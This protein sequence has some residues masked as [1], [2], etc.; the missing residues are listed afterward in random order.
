MRTLT[1]K[2][3]QAQ[4]GNSTNV[5]RPQGATPKPGMPAHAIGNLRRTM[6]NQAALRMIQKQKRDLDFGRTEAAAFQVDHDFTRTNKNAEATVESQARSTS[7]AEGGRG[8]DANRVALSAMPTPA[9]QLPANG[10]LQA[11]LQANSPA[12]TVV[13]PI[14]HEVVNSSGRPLDPATRGFMESRF[15]HDF[16]QVRVH[17]DAR[18]AKSARAVNASAYT[19]GRNVVF[20]TGQFEPATTQGRHLL[21][22]ELTHVVQQRA[23]VNLKNG[24]SEAGDPYERQ[25]DAVADALACGES[26]GVSLQRYGRP[27]T[28]GLSQQHVGKV[29]TV[30]RTPSNGKDKPTTNP[31]DPKLIEPTEIVE[32]DPV[33]E[34]ERAA[35][36]TAESGGEG[37]STQPPRKKAAWRKRGQHSRLFS[38]ALTDLFGGKHGKHLKHWIWSWGRVKFGKPVLSEEERNQELHSE[39]HELAS[40]NDSSVN[41]HDA[42]PYKGKINGT[43]EIPFLKAYTKAFDLP[44]PTPKLKPR[45]KITDVSID[46]T[47]T[48]SLSFSIGDPG[49]LAWGPRAPRARIVVEMQ[50]GAIFVPIYDTTLIT[51][52]KVWTTVS[53]TDLRPDSIYRVRVYT[54]YWKHTVEPGYQFGDDRTQVE[55]QLNINQ[56]ETATFTIV[57]KTWSKARILKPARHFRLRL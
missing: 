11:K 8:Q 40:A 9:P 34:A 53:L 35:D 29:S 22:H 16:S 15:G 46:K 12:K 52:G 48:G 1:H 23:G 25:A 20:G 38:G 4:N 18:A 56:Y 36:E 55:Y 54:D 33:E 7:R 44:V 41:A 45:E 17:S 10:R 57:K 2:Q 42:S 5:A 30:Q 6:G 31:T 51:T 28:L 24:V 14:V 27:P 26:T 37:D 32:E 21:T 50:D 13:P 19:V 3:N 49:D 47:V 39:H 43:V